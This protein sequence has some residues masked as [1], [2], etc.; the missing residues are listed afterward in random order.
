[1]KPRTSL[2][3][4]TY[5]KPDLI[6]KLKESL[7]KTIDTYATEWVVV[8]NGSD[9]ETPKIIKPLKWAKYIKHDNSGNFSSMNNMGV[10]HCTSDIIIFLNNDIE[11]QSDFPSRMHAIL[12]KNE[13]IGC[14]GAVLTYPNYVLQHAGV[15][16]T[17]QTSPANLGGL[18]VKLLKLRSDKVNPDAWMHPVVFNAATGAMLAVRKEDFEAIGGFDEIFDWAFEDVDLCIKMRLVREKICVVDPGCRAIHHESVS[19]GERM[20]KKNLMLFQGRYKHLLRPDYHK[21]L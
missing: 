19:G 7:E 8:D 6:L 4:L 11:S 20:V 12:S 17:E 21:F 10:K 9:P 15:I 3:T 5:N 18:A 1:M 14:V 13:L 2:L 16:I